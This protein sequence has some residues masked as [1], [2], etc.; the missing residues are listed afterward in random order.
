MTFVRF[1]SQASDVSP[2]WYDWKLRI[3]NQMCVLTQ[4]Y[5]IGSAGDEASRGFLKGTDYTD[6]MFHIVAHTN[7]R[8]ADR[9]LIGETVFGVKIWSHAEKE[10]ADQLALA[11]FGDFKTE[12]A[13]KS[14]WS[15][16]EKM[17]Q[18]FSGFWFYGTEAEDLMYRLAQGD[19]LPL[20]FFSGSGER[21]IE[22]AYQS[23]RR[24]RFPAWSEAFRA[25]VVAN[26]E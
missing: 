26:R 10:P 14:K 9:Y 6:V 21:M 23:E 2:Q 5:R 24:D 19:S 1:A 4:R 12:A 15:E 11:Q 22:T 20:V 7:S 8:D 18:A 3:D 16:S 17:S 13:E 25:C